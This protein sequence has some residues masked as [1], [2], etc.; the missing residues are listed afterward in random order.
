MIN[1][2]Q[3]KGFTMFNYRTITWSCGI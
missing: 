2:N 3:F 1:L